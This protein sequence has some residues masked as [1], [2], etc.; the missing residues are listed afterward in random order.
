M[1]KVKKWHTVALSSIYFARL[2]TL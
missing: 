2:Q 1:L